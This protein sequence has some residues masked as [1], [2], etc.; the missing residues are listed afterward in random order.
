MKGLLIPTNKGNKYVLPQ[1]IIR[2]EAS[3]S[4]CKI[5]FDNDYPLTVAKMLHWFENKLPEGFFYRIHR[6]HIV[7]RLFISE[8]SNSARITLLNG[9]TLQVSK[10]RK[11]EFK[12]MVA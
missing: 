12:R 1:N 5:Y 7:N 9:D 11:T 6:T 3:S 10:R 8:I 4:Y 2:V